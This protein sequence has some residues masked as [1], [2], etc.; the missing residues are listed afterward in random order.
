M[1][2]LEVY[3]NIFYL[4]ETHNNNYNVMRAR[5]ANNY[6]KLLPLFIG[7]LYVI[8]Y[9]LLLILL[10]RQDTSTHV[11]QHTAYLTTTT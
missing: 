11:A 5:C 3:Y 6:G 1:F 9:I 2:S 4:F 7:G 8:I 10:Y